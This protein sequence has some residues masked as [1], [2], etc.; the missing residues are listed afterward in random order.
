ME[1]HDF[2]DIKTLDEYLD[3]INGKYKHCIDDLSVV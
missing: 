3:K 2:K 1:N